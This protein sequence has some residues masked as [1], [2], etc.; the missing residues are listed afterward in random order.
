[1]TTRWI[2]GIARGGI[3]TIAACL[4]TILS[5]LA[6]LPATSAP[7][8]AP[9]TAGQFSGLFHEDDEPRADRSGFVSVKLTA[10]GAFSGY[11]QLGAARLALSGRFD[12]LSSTS[13]VDVARGNA[14]PITV[15]LSLDDT[16][17]LAGTVSDGTWSARLA[18]DRQVWNKT[19]RPATAHAGLYTT[20]LDRGSGGAEP[21]GFGYGTATVD[22][23]GALKFAGRLGDGSPVSQK[24]TLSKTG[25]WPVY[26][27]AYANRGAVLAWVPVSN[28]IDTAGRT[29]WTK[30]SGVPGSL[31]PAGFS[32]D[33]RLFCSPYVPPAP[34]ERLMQVSTGYITLEQGP[35]AQPLT[36]ELELGT[37]N[38]VRPLGA[39]GLSLKFTPKTGLFSGTV[40]APGGGPKIK[41]AGVV[42]QAADLAVGHF[43]GSAQSGSVVIAGD[44]P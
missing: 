17:T 27:P 19:T 32:L 7:A 11:L 35:L 5:T 12:S 23:A 22:S 1:M 29:L 21:G 4:G 16:D 15:R 34:G 38:K 26:L 3:T 44:T 42:F 36:T 33:P 28:H 30:P 25:L 8:A 37:D 39:Q 41:F 6:P 24:V 43:L 18:A 14:S 9:F 20:S 13:R 10:Q 2:T 40:N 31:Y